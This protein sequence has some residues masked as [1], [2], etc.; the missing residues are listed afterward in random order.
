MKKMTW[1]LI[2]IAVSFQMS[3]YAQEKIFSEEIKELLE[4]KDDRAILGKTLMKLDKMDEESIDR[5]ANEFISQC[6]KEEN[7]YLINQLAMRLYSASIPKA[8]TGRLL[9]TMREYGVLL[10]DDAPD[11]MMKN[12]NLKDLLTG[13]QQILLFFYEA[14]C[15]ICHEE[16]ENLKLLQATLETNHITL[17]SIDCNASEETPQPWQYNV[18]DPKGEIYFPYGIMRTPTYILIDKEGKVSKRFSK[19][20]EL[21]SN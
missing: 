12:S 8:P 13:D 21:F 3:M 1:V 5:F 10:G 14:S 11:F 18:V 20:D 4:Q 17:V 16:L 19:L 2:L 6:E 7:H 15:D 9:K